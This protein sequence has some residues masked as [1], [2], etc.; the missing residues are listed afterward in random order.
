MV[1]PHVA[2]ALHEVVTVREVDTAHRGV[3]MVPEEATAVVPHHL[4]GTAEE[5]AVMVLLLAWVLGLEARLRLATLLIRT[6]DLKVAA[7][8][9]RDHHQVKNSLWPE[10]LR[11]LVT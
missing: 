11:L 4:D 5:E 1:L 8:T 10:A 6:T 7:L 3:V 9:C 2:T